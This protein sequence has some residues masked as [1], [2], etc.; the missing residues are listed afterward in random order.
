MLSLIKYIKIELERRLEESGC[1]RLDA[2]CPTS[3]L[4]ALLRRDL[5]TAV[6]GNRL[7]YTGV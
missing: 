2:D 1:Q 6:D 7:I 5:R 3:G 4:F